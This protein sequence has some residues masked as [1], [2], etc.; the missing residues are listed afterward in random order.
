VTGTAP[1]GPDTDAL[2]VTDRGPVRWIR[3]DRA[4]KRNAMTRAM[5]AHLRQLLVDA[6]DDEAV[7]V[8]VLTGTGTTFSAG[9]DTTDMFGGAGTGAAITEKR[10]TDE[11]IFPV[12]ELVQFPKPT[13]CALNGRA[14]GGG[15]TMAMAADLR[16]CAASA[17]LAFTLARLGL[18][19]EWGSS[20]LLW[21]QIGWGRTLD[22]LL[23]GREI[24]ASEASTLGLV[25]RVVP[26]DA[27]DTE[28]QALAEQLA[29][30]PPGTAEEIKA[31]LRA[32]LDASF[33]DARRNELRALGRRG[34]ALAE[35]RRTVS[36][37]D[38]TDPP[39][40]EQ[41]QQ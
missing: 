34:K 19:P 4:E 27:L 5:A 15:A 40:K 25:E 30:L 37:G 22:V 8:V 18:T 38:G 10:P 1:G 29:S 16:V 12:D 14:V 31:V 39:T 3:I 35:Q 11:P 24:T 9:F 23:T 2:R 20:Y 7:R 26:D 33:A 21:R 32:G 17:T 6:A 41:A 36:L 13:I 28:T